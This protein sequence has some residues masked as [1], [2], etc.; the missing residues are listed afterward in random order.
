M[1][2]GVKNIN[3]D[4][5]DKNSILKKDELLYEEYRMILIN[6]NKSLKRSIN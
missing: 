4:L 3:K 1:R 5:Y 6:E 2:Y